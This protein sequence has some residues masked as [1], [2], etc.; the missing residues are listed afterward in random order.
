M[1]T[2]TR[3]QQLKHLDMLADF[4]LKMPDDFAPDDSVRFRGDVDYK[5]EDINYLKDEKDK[6]VFKPVVYT[7]DA[8]SHLDINDYESWIDVY[9]YVYAIDIIRANRP[10]FYTLDERW[11]YISPIKEVGIRIKY[12]LANQLDNCEYDSIL[13]D[14]YLERINQIGIEK[15]RDVYR[16]CMEK[17]RVKYM[18]WWENKNIQESN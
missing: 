3:E 6:L 1:K 13:R 9:N 18:Q 8:M 15:N 11:L 14:L 17:I 4:L 16:D 12:F 5:K 7:F 10:H 2:F